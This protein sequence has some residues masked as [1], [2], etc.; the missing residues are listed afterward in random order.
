MAA[1]SRHGWNVAAL[2]SRGY[3]QSD[4]PYATFGGREAS[5]VR[6]WMDRLAECAARK[7]AP[8]VFRP[9]LWGRSMGTQI[10]LRTAAVDT[11]VVALVL[12]SPLVDLAS[13]V[14]VPLRKRRFPMSGLLARLILR[15]A[16]K[17]AGMPLDRP[18]PIDLAP[19]VACAVLILHG[20]GDTL[21]PAAEARRLAA[22]FAD[23]PG[24]IDVKGAG[25]SD[26]VDTGGEP[27][28]DQVAAFLGKAA[29]GDE[30][31]GTEVRRNAG[32][33]NTQECD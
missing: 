18:R 1:L 23:P 27:L 7:A 11:R 6:V 32:L 12:E 2:D 14:A 19:R 33:Q 28:V 24:W 30:P 3:G 5:D 31:V 26:V 22:A 20:S 17:L 15:R 21:V 13:A 10:A 29:G 9:A 4:G 25:H 8:A 16:A